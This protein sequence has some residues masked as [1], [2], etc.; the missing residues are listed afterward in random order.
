M[1][2]HR[3]KACRVPCNGITFT[4]RNDMVTRWR[5]PPRPEKKFLG[6]LQGR[7]GSGANGCVK[8][9]VGWRLSGS[10]AECAGTAASPEVDGRLA[11]CER[12][13]PRFPAERAQARPDRRHRN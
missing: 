5:G 3:A 6:M 7:A 13:E 1:C 11:E 4:N 10:L 8:A 2:A 9:I 12:E